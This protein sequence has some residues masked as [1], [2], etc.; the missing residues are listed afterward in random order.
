MSDEK[1][2]DIEIRMAYQDD[3]IQDLSDV[4]YKQQKQI[5]QL[6]KMMELMLGKLQDLSQ[7]PTTKHLDEKPPHY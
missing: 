6:E 7:N 2:I 4:V 1:I 5:D 3:I